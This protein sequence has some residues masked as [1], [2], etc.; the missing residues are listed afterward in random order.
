LDYARKAGEWVPNQH[1]GNENL[2]AVEFLI[3]TFPLQADR[4]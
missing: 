2:G 1:G 4:A 3:Y